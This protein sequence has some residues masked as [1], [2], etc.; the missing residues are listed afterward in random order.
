MQAARATRKGVPRHFIKYSWISCTKRGSPWN[1]LW[2]SLSG[3]ETSK[4]K[5]EIRRF[6]LRQNDDFRVLRQNDDFRVL[7]QMT[8]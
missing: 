4:C 8:A 1:D 5:Y 3:E 7:R 2:I 6:W